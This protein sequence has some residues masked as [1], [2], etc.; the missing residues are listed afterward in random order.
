M[1]VTKKLRITII[2][3]LALAILG[4]FLYCNH[5]SSVKSGKYYFEQFKNAGIFVYYSEETGSLLNEEMAS[6]YLTGLADNTSIDKIIHDINLY[7]DTVGL[8]QLAN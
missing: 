4:V 6:Y 7:L 1:K 8:P 3:L 2:G 5:L